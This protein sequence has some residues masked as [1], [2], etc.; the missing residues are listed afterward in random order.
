M[1]TYK[2]LSILIFI[3]IFLWSCE[4][5]KE[6]VP[7][8]SG[9]SLLFSSL[10]SANEVSDADNLSDEYV[11]VNLSIFLTNVGSATVTDKFIHV[12]FSPAGGT[13]VMNYQQARLSALDPATIGNKD[14]YVIANCLDVASLNAVQTVTDLQALKTPVVSDH[15]SLTTINGLPMF[16]QLLNAALSD[17]TSNNPALVSLSRTCSKLRITLF[18]TS[19]TWIGTGNAF[20]IENAAPYTYYIRNN[21]FRFDSSALISYSSISLNP[22][23][24]DPQ[25][26]QNVTYL[27]E[28]LQL[29]YLHLRTTIN[30]V[31]EEYIVSSNF[32]LPV[33]NYLYDIQIQILPPATSSPPVSRKTDALNYKV[34]VRGTEVTPKS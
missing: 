12:P 13:P 7:E 28:S 30:G 1:K 18:F 11:I 26:F 31:P 19:D 16:G 10:K 24:G 21:T 2:V 15:S 27:Y 5:D 9:V 14:V 34:V 33:R 22:V 6:I 17:A 8:P 20:T 32:P 4:D 23:P 25:R 29:P 3:G